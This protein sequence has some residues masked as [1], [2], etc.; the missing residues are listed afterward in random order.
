MSKN[1]E[2]KNFVYHNTFDLHN[3]LLADYEYQYINF[4]DEKKKS[5]RSKHKFSDLF[6]DD[7]EYYKY[8]D[9]ESD[10]IP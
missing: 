3:N 8:F 5:K 10:D 1:L 4:S 6:L 2:Q 7:Y 9:E